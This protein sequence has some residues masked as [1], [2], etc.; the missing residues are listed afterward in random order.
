MNQRTTNLP[1]NKQQA[2]ILKML[3]CLSVELEKSGIVVFSGGCNDYAV[4]I[5][6]ETGMILG[7]DSTSVWM[8]GD[9]NVEEINGIQYCKTVTPSAEGFFNQQ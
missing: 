3:S 1:S 5:H 2:K 7:Q 4:L 8:G 9:L 6:R